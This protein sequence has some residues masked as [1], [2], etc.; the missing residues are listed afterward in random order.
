MRFLTSKFSLFLISLIFISILFWMNFSSINSFIKLSDGQASTSQQNQLFIKLG[1]H[2]SGFLKWLYD[3]SRPFAAEAVKYLQ[4][5]WANQKAAMT[6]AV[7]HWLVNQQESL[8]SALQSQLE[9]YIDKPF[10]PIWENPS[11]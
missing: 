10:K 4:A 7:I 1:D 8:S 3:F 6:N 2:I 9:R 5:W 11:K